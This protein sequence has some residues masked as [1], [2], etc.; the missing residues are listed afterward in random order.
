MHIDCAC[1]RAS[2]HTACSNTQ[3]RA[4]RLRSRT[5]AAAGTRTR[6]LQAACGRHVPCVAQRHGRAGRRAD[7]RHPPQKQ[8]TRWQPASLRVARPRRRLRRARR[9][10]RV[11]AASPLP[12]VA[13][14]R[15]EMSNFCRSP[16][17]LKQCRG[18]PP[19]QSQDHLE[20]GSFRLGKTAEKTTK[21]PCSPKMLQTLSRAKAKTVKK[22]GVPPEKKTTKKNAT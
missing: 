7:G 1:G 22:K 9:P 6:M 5:C 16:K 13:R 17:M 8:R 2:A 14:M 20:I 18:R 15:S 11:A 4:R 19:G 10:R 21:R 3:L 12:G